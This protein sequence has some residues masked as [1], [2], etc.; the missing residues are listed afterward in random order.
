[1]W[2]VYYYVDQRGKCPVKEFIDGKKKKNQAKILAWIELLSREGPHL[3]RPYADY[4]GDGI[5]ELR[6]KTGTDSGGSE[7]RILYFFFDGDSIVLTHGFTKIT[8][9]VPV[10]ELKRARQI[11]DEYLN[12]K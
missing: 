9:R 3:P 1:M 12:S 6:I 10:R 5:H 4:L 7:N 11:K 2:N 8:D